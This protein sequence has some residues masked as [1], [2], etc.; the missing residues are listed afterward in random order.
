[1]FFMLTA[2]VFFFFFIQMLFFRKN[3]YLRSFLQIQVARWLLVISTSRYKQPCS[4]LLL[5]YLLI[6]TFLSVAQKVRWHILP[7][8]FP[9]GWQSLCMRWSAC[10]CFIIIS[11]RFL[12]RLYGFL[13]LVQ[14]PATPEGGSRASGCWMELLCALVGPP[15][16]LLPDFSSAVA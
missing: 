8:Y 1:M 11:A 2:S 5:K 13:T 10:W 15:I 6:D 4:P 9:E 3:I 16:I 12:L 7:Y 14:Y